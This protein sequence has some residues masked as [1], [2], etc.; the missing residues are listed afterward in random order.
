VLR[1]VAAVNRDGAPRP[2]AARRVGELA[3]EAD[4]R[5]RATARRRARAGRRHRADPALG[6]AAH[7]DLRRPTVHPVRCG[8]RPA[9]ATASTTT[10][11][12]EPARRCARPAAA[13]RR[14]PVGRLA[15]RSR[16]ISRPGLGVLDAC[17][18]STLCALPA[19]LA[20]TAV[21]L[22]AASEGPPSA[23]NMATAARIV[24][25]CRVRDGL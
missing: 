14:D 12:L 15:W 11:R 6:P 2:L 1:I 3:A 13:R 5:R 17:G 10:A 25:G 19:R 21:A 24:A 20:N 9:S 22:D 4:R 16:A 23:T 8:W 18:P 7:G